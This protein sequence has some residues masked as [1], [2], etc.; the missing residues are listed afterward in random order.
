VKIRLSIIVIDTG[1][2]R[3]RGMEKWKEKEQQE[4]IMA[5][6]KLKKALESVLE[7]QLKADENQ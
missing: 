6:S 1:M 4:P 2:K 7:I 3:T 5:C